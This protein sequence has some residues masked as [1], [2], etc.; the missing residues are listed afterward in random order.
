MIQEHEGSSRQGRLSATIYGSHRSLTLT[1]IAWTSRALRKFPR[2]RSMPIRNEVSGTPCSFPSCSSPS[3][4]CSWRDPRFARALAAETWYVMRTWR[5]QRP[6]RCA[7][8]LVQTSSVS[9]SRAVA[10]RVGKVARDVLEPHDADVAARAGFRSDPDLW[11]VGLLLHSVLRAA[12]L[13]LRAYP[14]DD[15]VLAAPGDMLR[16]RVV[17]KGGPASI[18]GTPHE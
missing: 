16:W 4:V 12:R 9:R 15:T 13:S 11:A 18:E 17:V 7:T 5:R 1:D 3:P 10:D 8:Q 2:T 14:Y 6:P